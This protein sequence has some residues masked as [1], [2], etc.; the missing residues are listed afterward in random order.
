LVGLGMRQLSMHPSQILSVKSQI[1]QC[2]E[3]I[4]SRQAKKILSFSDLEKIEPL[5]RKFNGEFA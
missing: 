5:V 2:E 1:L 3:A 4:L